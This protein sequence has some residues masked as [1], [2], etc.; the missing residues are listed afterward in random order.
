MKTYLLSFFVLT[1]VAFSACNKGGDF[2]EKDKDEWTDKDY[3]DKDYVDKDGCFDLVYPVTY[4]MPDGTTV[5]GNEEELKSAIESWY[6]NHP[7]VAAKPELQ[8]PV[9]ISFYDDDEIITVDD[10]E[11]MIAI[12]ED[13]EG[14]K[15]D[16]F[17]LVY[18]VTYI[19]PDGSSI[20]GDNEE[21][22]KAAMEEWYEAHPDVAAKPELQ[23]P[24]Q[25]SFDDGDEVITVANVEEMIVIKE[26]CEEDKWDCFDFVYPLTYIMPDG[27]SI[28]GDDKESLY[29]AMEA[30]YE[31]HPDVLAEATLQFPVQISYEDSDQLFT[32]NNEAELEAAYENCD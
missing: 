18:P 24:V 25:I 12:K 10:E 30:W 21:A 8:Y 7:D 31:A 32:I 19:M 6:D 1:F 26:D 3:G 28:T 22:L 2:D 11:K 27:S 16:C 17:D 5:T 4:I 13:C 23:Y 29:A 15:W 14:E 20:T 9:Q